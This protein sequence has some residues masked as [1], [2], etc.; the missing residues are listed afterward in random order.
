MV[1]SAHGRKPT[2]EQLAAFESF[3]D[4]QAAIHG[5]VDELAWADLGHVLINMKDFYYLD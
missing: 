3:L 5:K 1:E 4:Q 2:E